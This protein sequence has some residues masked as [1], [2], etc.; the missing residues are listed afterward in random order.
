M[1]SLATIRA[2]VRVDLHD[3]ADTKLWEDATLTRH[4]ERAL[5]EYSH[6]SPI[7]Q[8]TALP[9]DADARTVDVSSLTP[10]IRI[11]ATE[12]PTGEYPPL[13]VP[14]T[15][16]G[17]VLTLDIATA[18]AG[19]PN[20]N[21]FWHKEH[22]ING[23]V[24][25]PSNHDQLIATGAAGF[26]AIEWASFATN[27]VNTAGNNVWGMY[28]DMGHE[29]LKSFREQL[30]DLPAASR[31]RTARLYSPTDRRLTSQTTDPGPL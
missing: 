10:R 6:V 19:T 16:W 21:I 25:F 18:P 15:I 1:S 8:K 29:R 17:E 7:E 14:F 30:Q 9:T 22:S 26:A 23:S 3:E 5:Q 11:V 24:T 12:H 28:A 13:Y 31:V 2:D 4:I 27:R 20:I